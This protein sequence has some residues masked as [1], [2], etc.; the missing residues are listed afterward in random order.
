VIILPDSYPVQKG[1]KIP[2]L[3]LLNSSIENH[4]HYELGISLGDEE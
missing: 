3:A 4:R 1:E 2:C